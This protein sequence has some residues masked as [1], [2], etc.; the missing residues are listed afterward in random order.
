MCTN[1]ESINILRGCILLGLLHNLR[2]SLRPF[3][4]CII[5][6]FS[7][8]KLHWLFSITSNQVL[9]FN[10]ISRDIEGVVTA[11]IEI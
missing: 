6:Y 7:M 10:K 8:S 3:N 2:G 4:I 1:N 5:K 9:F 11:L